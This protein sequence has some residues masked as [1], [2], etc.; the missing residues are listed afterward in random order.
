MK[1]WVSAF[2]YSRHFLS[3][4]M[5]ALT[6]DQ[7]EK[8]IRFRGM[9]RSF[10]DIAAELGLSVNTV[11]SYFRRNKD[12]CASNTCK[13]CGK[14]II[15]PKGTREKKFCSDACRMK[16]WNSHRDEVNRKSAA[17]VTCACCGK[18]VI[19]YGKRKYCSRS[20]YMSARFGG[21]EHER[22]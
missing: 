17:A 16:W 2:G 1:P 9:G 8:I 5:I 4:E 20:C 15:Q 19:F 14:S 21:A 13:T 3:L 11:K 12:I 6:K 18:E 22:G 10:G 7:K